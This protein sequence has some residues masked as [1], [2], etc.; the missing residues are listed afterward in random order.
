M[1]RDGTKYVERS[2][3]E[4]EKEYQHRKLAHVRRQTHSI[5]CDLIPRPSVT[6]AWPKSYFIFHR[7]VSPLPD[8]YSDFPETANSELIGPEIVYEFNQQLLVVTRLLELC[9]GV[10]AKSGLDSFF[11]KWTS[12]RRVL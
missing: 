1:L 5:G 7:R 11:I 8:L 6:T 2:I 9:N 12:S 10:L 3:E 4:F